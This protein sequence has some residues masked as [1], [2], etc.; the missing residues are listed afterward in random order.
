ML[1]T[2]RTYKALNN[3]DIVCDVHSEINQ[4]YYKFRKQSYDKIDLH[5]DIIQLLEVLEE[6]PNV[7]FDFPTRSEYTFQKN[8]VK[9][10]TM[11]IFPI[12]F[13]HDTRRHLYFVIS[14]NLDRDTTAFFISEC[15]DSQMKVF[16]DLYKD[17]TIANI[18]WCTLWQCVD[19]I[20]TKWT[21]R[22]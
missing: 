12:M 22:F 14:Q 19:T 11:S 10:R 13:Y 9:Y 8:M 2:Y 20:L 16:S 21:S 7:E 18:H 6:C 1:R 17:L 3:V 15:P 4:L 5:P